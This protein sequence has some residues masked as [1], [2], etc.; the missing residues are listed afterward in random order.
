MITQDSTLC[1]TL[2]TGQPATNTGEAP[3]ALPADAGVPP[4]KVIRLAEQAR[5]AGWQVTSHT[6][7][8]ADGPW[9]ALTLTGR[10]RSGS[11]SEPAE[12]RCRWATD[13][14]HRVRWRGACVHR[15]GRETAQGIGW[16][17]LPAILQELAAVLI[18]PAAEEAGHTHHGRGA[19]HW[20]SAALGYAEQAAKALAA[21]ERDARLRRPDG[22]AQELYRLQRRAG[23]AATAAGAAQ[24]AAGREGAAR[25]VFEV[26][27]RVRVLAKS[28]TEQAE[29]LRMAALAGEAAAVCERYVAQDAA[30]LAASEAQWRAANPG[31]AAGQFAHTVLRTIGRADAEFAQWW[32]D[33]AT[34]GMTYLQGWDAW[35]A[36]HATEAELSA[37]LRQEPE[38]ARALFALGTAAAAVVAAVVAAAGD[39]QEQRAERMAEAAHRGVGLFAPGARRTSREVHRLAVEVWSLLGGGRWGMS[40]DMAANIPV[41]EPWLTTAAGVEAAEVRRLMLVRHGLN[42]RNQAH[43]VVREE[44]EAADRLRAEAARAV[45]EAAVAAGESEET[46]REAARDARARLDADA[47]GRPEDGR[48][49]LLRGQA[50]WVEPAEGG[51]RERFVSLLACYLGRGL[52]RVRSAGSGEVFDADGGTL[53]PATAEEETADRCRQ[54]AEGQQRAARQQR[55]RAAA[56]EQAAHEEAA[57]Q[58]CEKRRQ[59]RSAAAQDC[60][61]PIAAAGRWAPAYRVPESVAALWQ[62]AARNGWAMTRETRGSGAA[63]AVVVCVNGTTARGKWEFHLVWTVTHGA[64]RARKQAS[65]AVWADGRSGPRGGQVRP[66]VTDALR[67]LAAETVEGA[68]AAVGVL[69]CAAVPGLVTGDGASLAG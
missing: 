8:D 31:G 55:E 63:S 7:T 45:Y 37:S 68:A 24:R 53:A 64:Y 57:R 65:A 35:H 66:G 23:A 36:G 60:S 9:F 49:R 3:P 18:D 56:D 41:V 12:V 50:V 40:L 42:L 1:T 27:E 10:L 38:H 11:G 46:A 58:A 54:L 44:L 29:A 48:G 59:A 51:S 22:P 14:M 5:Q 39:D 4:T 62:S 69:V 61:A 19:E 13:G 21:G 32:E 52:F 67:V 17:L 30:A 20:T 34:P 16:R 15:A 43:A 33:H 2:P 6:G 25:R 28:C 47:A 26:S